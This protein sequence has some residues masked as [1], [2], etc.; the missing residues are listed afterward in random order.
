M[1][2]LFVLTLLLQVASDTLT[3]Q[4]CYTAAESHFPLSD[5]IALQDEIASL[6]QDNLKASSLPS[7]VLG[8]QALYFSDVATVT[9]PVSFGATNDQ[10]KTSVLIEQA[11]YD[12]G[13][14]SIQRKISDQQS[15]VEKRRV[16]VELYK[17]REQV[18]AAFMGAL[19]FDAQIATLDTLS[20]EL[21]SQ[22]SFIESMVENGVMLKSN[23]D[24]LRV[25][26]L[27][28]RQR[29][30]E[31][32]SNRNA[33][34]AVLGLLIGQTI[35]T[36]VVLQTPRPSL[37]NIKSAEKRQPEYQLF[38]ASRLLL[39]SQSALK[40]KRLNPQVG[41]FVEGA[42][43]RPAGLNLFETSI[44]P[45]YNLGIRMQWKP[46]DWRITHRERQILEVQERVIAAQ[47]E[48]F[49]TT[50]SLILERQLRQIEL[51]EEQIGQDDEIVNLRAS[52]TREAGTRLAQGVLT[53]SQYV[54]EV[55]AESQARLTR[56]LHQLQLTQAKLN[57]LTTL[58]QNP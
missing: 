6:L 46:W 25:E 23:A 8:A 28:N 17:L 55:N 7:I 45:F 10:Y 2:L 47:E 51:L 30:A 16:E 20:K 44:T 27:R 35:E 11:I 31:A 9:G 19:L 40:A 13:L 1:T 34:R 58:G 56:Q 42:I 21:Q 38:Q 24:V 36:D 29:I 49:T 52:I 3:V 14:K 12:G 57:H 39:R 15:E 22:L 43:G 37:T 4:E 26:L 33:M 18:N 5:T 48:A 53:A 32:T 54:T 50:T 41:A